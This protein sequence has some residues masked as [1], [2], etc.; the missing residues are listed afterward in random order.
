MTTFAVVKTRIDMKRGIFLLMAFSIMLA[1]LASC[2]T[3]C[4]C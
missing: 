1:A 3:P 2:A 4:G